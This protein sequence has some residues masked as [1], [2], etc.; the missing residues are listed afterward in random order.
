MHVAGELRE[1]L[2]LL[3]TSLAADA[4]NFRKAHGDLMEDY[5]RQICCGIRE[6]L[7]GFRDDVGRLSGD[8]PLARRL[9][10]RTTDYVGQCQSALRDLPVF[11]VALR[12]ERESFRR[13]VA[14]C[15]MIYLSMRL[16]G[17]SSMDLPEGTDVLLCLHG[18]LQL[19][20]STGNGDGRSPLASLF[21]RY[22]ALARKLDDIENHPRNEQRGHPNLVSLLRARSTAAPRVDVWQEVEAIV[23]GEFLDLGIWADELPCLERGIA[24]LKLHES[25][26]SAFGLGL[27][28]EA[29]NT[30]PDSR[31]PSA[32]AGLHAASLVEE[33]LESRGPEALEAVACGACGAG[34]GEEL[35]RK[36]GFAV[37]RCLFCSHVYVSPRLAGSLA[38]HPGGENE[39]DSGLT[40]FFAAERLNAAVVCDVVSEYCAGR[41]WLHYGLAGG[42][43]PREAMA[44]GAQVYAADESADA[45]EALRPLLGRR[46]W[47]V[48]RPLGELPW[49]PHDAVLLQHTAELF[50]DPRSA[51]ERA[52]RALRPRGLLYVAV[53]G[54][55]SLQ[56]RMLGRHWE[57]V[58]PVLRWH[59]FVR[60][61]L[62]RL[63]A[64]CGFAVVEWL[65]PPPLPASLATPW[66]QLFRRLGGSEAGE[67]TVLARARR[68][69]DAG[70]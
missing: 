23:G 1:R 56:F 49:G 36:Q 53:P 35:F 24:R 48:G 29:A 25:L 14:S 9:A 32:A 27:F 65:E 8:N 66:M 13:A 30:P 31:P 52:N 59:Y 41:R 42:H 16:L 34:G 19:T 44:R 17:E 6:T 45:L 40:S 28:R 3:R 51:L 18:I 21:D 67:L 20:G 60:E 57:A 33:I 37:R 50:R 64:D 4:E 39:N 11:A 12:P 10:E 43:L 47:Q 22:Y 55:D 5:R 15:G 70:R 61:S 63:L 54:A 68:S 58:S 38:P 46:L 62:E 7:E 69:G 26:E 2:A